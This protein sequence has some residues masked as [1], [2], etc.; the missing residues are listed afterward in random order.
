[1]LLPEFW[2][3]QASP[4]PP[5]GPPTMSVTWTS[6][7]RSPCFINPLFL[8]PSQPSR[9]ASHK[10]HR[11]KRSLR[12]RVSTESS[13]SLTPGDSEWSQG[14]SDV[15]RSNERMARRAGGL[16]M[17]RRTAALVP[18]SEEEDEQMLGEVPP[19]SVYVWT[20]ACVDLR[21]FFCNSGGGYG[22]LNMTF[23][24]FTSS[25]RKCLYSSIL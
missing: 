9:E 2:S 19:V 3:S 23:A 7:P 5:N 18:T 15:L 1:M 6:R 11:L 12:V 24:C 25:Y 8:Q 21:V 14:D 17:L 4:G 16:S 10:R 22:F 13:F 20:H